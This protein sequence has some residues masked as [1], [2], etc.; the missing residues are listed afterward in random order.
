MWYI[1][2]CKDGAKLVAGIDEN[3]SM[4]ELAK[5]C[6]N[7]DCEKYLKYIPVKK[8]DTVFIPAGLVHAI[9]EG[10]MEICEIPYFCCLSCL[11]DL[12]NFP[13]GPVAIQEI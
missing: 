3:V 13:G 10:T 2:D 11:L 6:E 7:G 1:L 4:D 5:A 8:G 12:F 9:G